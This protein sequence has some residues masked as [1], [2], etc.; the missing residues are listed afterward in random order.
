MAMR[1]R[2]PFMVSLSALAMFLGANP[3]E[4]AAQ[5]SGAVAGLGEESG[6]SGYPFQAE[7]K[8]TSLT[9]PRAEANLTEP[10]THNVARNTRGRLRIDSNMGKSKIQNAGSKGTE[11]QY[12]RFPLPRP[13][14]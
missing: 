7:V 13:C 4:T 5:C 8:D 1:D 2:T 10:L 11:D 14:Y 6:L 3:L 9:Q 12:K